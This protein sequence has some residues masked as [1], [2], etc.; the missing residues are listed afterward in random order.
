MMHTKRL[1]QGITAVIPVMTTLC[2]TRAVQC[3][4]WDIVE[5]NRPAAASAEPTHALGRIS[6]IT[7]EKRSRWK[8]YAMRPGTLAVSQLSWSHY[9]PAGI[10]GYILAARVDPGWGLKPAWGT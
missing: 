8:N 1:H 9:I 10:V 4:E 6:N 7:R 5:F 2:D 3:I